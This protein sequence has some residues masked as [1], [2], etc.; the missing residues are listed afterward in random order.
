MQQPI[1]IPM[2]PLSFHMLAVPIYPKA[3][4]KVVRK[5]TGH[6]PSNDECMI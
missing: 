2:L 1:K 6:N 4:C 3:Y 5:E